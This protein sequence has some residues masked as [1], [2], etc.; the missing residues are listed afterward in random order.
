MLPSSLFIFLPGHSCHKWMWC[1]VVKPGGA[2]HFHTVLWQRLNQGVRT[3]NVKVAFPLRWQ[4]FPRARIIGYCLGS[5]KKVRRKTVNAISFFVAVTAGWLDSSWT[6]IEV[7]KGRKKKSWKKSKLT[8]FASLRVSS[9]FSEGAQKLA[10]CI[11]QGGGRQRNYE[12][13]KQEE[14][15]AAC[16]W[17][18]GA[19]PS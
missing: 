5:E 11:Q 16:W 1:S 19:R 9:S 15:I 8:L 18:C 14:P 2:P 12:K 3:S 10:I 6:G 4:R 17:G 7:W 13:A